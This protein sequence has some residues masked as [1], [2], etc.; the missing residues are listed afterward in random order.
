VDLEGIGRILLFT[1]IG[2]AV[3]GGILL[4]LSRVPFLNDL[5]SLPGDIRIE[6]QGFS[7]IIPLVSM[8]LISI[9][10]TV[11]LNILARLINR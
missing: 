3:L 11:A 6:G 5:G 2:L 1:G 10:L 8:L 7:C 4:L 9:I